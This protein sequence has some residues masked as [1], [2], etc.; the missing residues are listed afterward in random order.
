MYLSI[1]LLLIVISALLFIVTYFNKYNIYE[2]Y[3]NSKNTS[4]FIT[5]N[6]MNIEETSYPIDITILAN[7]ID[8][9]KKTN[10][11]NKQLLGISSGFNT[12]DISLVID[13][14]INNY[15]LLNDSETQD[16]KEGIFVCLSSFK[17]GVEKC[18]WDFS[19]KVIGYI[20]MSDY[21]FI[22][23]MIKAYRQDV[24]VN[25]ITIKRLRPEDLK[26]IDKQFDYLFTYV[27]LDSKY[28]EYLKYSKYYINGMN[29]VDIY[30]IKAFYPFITEN[31]N[32][33]R[34]YFN[35]NNND[36][37]YDIYL[38]NE[39][40]LIPTMKY[41]IIRS[42]GNQSTLEN[43]ITRL[44]MPTDYLEGVEKEYD[45]KLNNKGKYGCY[46]NSKI[47]SKFECDSLYT[48]EGNVKNYY[49][50]WDKKCSINEECPY[51]KA[52]KNYPNERG[53]CVNGSCEFPVGVKRLGFKKYSDKLLNSPMCYECQNTTDY[54]CCSRISDINDTDD[55]DKSKSKEKNDYV[56]E[57]DFNERKKYD[58]N[59][60]ISLLDYRGL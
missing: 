5:E 58:L 20:Y 31:Y 52:N 10:K 23:A 35:N 26:I 48:N 6:V 40:S 54:N 37:T 21:L 4:L 51:Y 43:F 7:V 15:V 12:D 41:K 32:N 57:N 44:D 33:I 49:S 14:Y 1:L 55:I 17:L 9:M 29:D 34:Y 25:N 50:I 60:I 53:G 56:F 59:T 3:V 30:R 22:Q 8:D 19:N 45:T 47:T 2:R 11:L 24:N 16:Y 18:I 39:K 27:V 42:Q 28:M 13:P 46:G 38:S 36:K